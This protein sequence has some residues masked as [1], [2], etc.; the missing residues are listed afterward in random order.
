MGIL[1]WT[2][3]LTLDVEALIYSPVICNVFEEMRQN[4]YGK[5]MGEYKHGENNSV[6]TL[7]RVE[8]MLENIV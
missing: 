6:E 3:W 2:V 8:V 7:N 4:M 5:S 1:T